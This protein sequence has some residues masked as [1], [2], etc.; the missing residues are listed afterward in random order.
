MKYSAK[1][2]NKIIHQVYRHKRPLMYD[3]GGI[4]LYLNKYTFVPH[5]DTFQL[6]S[7]AT[8]IIQKNNSIETI[9]DIGTGSGVIA[10]KLAG[11]FPDKNVIAS[12]NSINALAN[13][14]EN[15][16]LNGVTAQFLL[17]TNDVWL[18]EYKKQK[19]DLIVSNPPF[20]GEA[21][22]HSKKFKELYPDVRF[23]PTQA[24]LVKDDEGG[25]RAYI[26]IIKN[27]RKNK[28]RFFLFQCNSDTILDLKKHIKDILPNSKMN[29]YKDVR[30]CLRFVYIEVQ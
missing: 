25:H 10:L 12:D 19:L 17:N 22:Y 23:E 2:R 9:G 16:N 7:L 3:I 13:A 30:N 4:S 6:I 11:A 29:L 27:S 14:K 8:Q 5:P 15:A 21:E 28:T 24:I 20:V 18:S 1:D 26:D